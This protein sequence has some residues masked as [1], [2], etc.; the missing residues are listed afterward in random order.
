MTKVD[1]TGRDDSYFAYECSIGNKNKSK[2]YIYKD[3][4]EN[5]A[6]IDTE[7]RKRLFEAIEQIVHPNT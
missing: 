3:I 5:I 1:I 2:C 4:D 6:A 7:P